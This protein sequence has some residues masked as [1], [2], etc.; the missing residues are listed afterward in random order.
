LLRQRTRSTNLVGREFLARPGR[1]AGERQRNCV[2]ETAG[3]P[4][5]VAV[6][7][8][9]RLD[10]SFDSGDVLLERSQHR[11][12]LVCERDLRAPTRFRRQLLSPLIFFGHGVEAKIRSE[13]LARRG[14][15]AP[16]LMDS[17][18]DGGLVEDVRK[19]MG[20]PAEERWSVRSKPVR[21]MPI[22]YGTEA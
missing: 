13:P 8:L 19:Q 10:R 1:A 21:R 7:V 9:L 6:E 18:R 4:V 14:L 15:E 17:V 2:P 16:A 3:A 11:E 12:L 22:S 5:L 20:T